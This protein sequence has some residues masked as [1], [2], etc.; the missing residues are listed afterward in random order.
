[1]LPR[2]LAAGRPPRGAALCHRLGTC[3]GKWGEAVFLSRFLKIL[4]PPY[5]SRYCCFYSELGLGIPE[6][7]TACLIGNSEITTQHHLPPSW[8][9]K[10]TTGKCQY[11]TPAVK[12]WSQHR[13]GLARVLGCWPETLVF[14]PL[15][16]RGTGQ[17]LANR[18]W[19][20]QPRGRP[21]E[22]G[23]VRGLL[24][25]ICAQTL[26]G[27]GR[28][29]VKSPSEQGGGQCLRPQSQESIRGTVTVQTS[30]QNSQNPMYQGYSMRL[31]DIFSCSFSMLFI[32]RRPSRRGRPRRQRRA[33]LVRF[34]S[35]KPW[36]LRLLSGTEVQ[37]ERWLRATGFASQPAPC[38]QTPGAHPISSSG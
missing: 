7:Q 3:L 16:P 15:P 34:L 18:T 13:A 22:P 8:V 30:G 21:Q 27:Q 14:L 19:P 11:K 6:R 33:S 17:V 36:M 9:L 25:G 23:P 1:M 28:G 37:P 20:W 5:R 10:A 35:R 4:P 12:S 31:R 38:P 26:Q 2:G 29:G 32:E 24:M